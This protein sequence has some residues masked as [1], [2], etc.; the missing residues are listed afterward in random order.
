MAS[1]IDYPFFMPWTQ[2]DRQHYFEKGYVLIRR[3]IDGDTLAQIDAQFLALA[4]GTAKVSEKMVIMKD[5]AYLSRDVSGESPLHEIN[6]LLSFE[7]DPILW[8]FATD[9]RILECVRDLVGPDVMTLSTNVFNKPPGLDS[10]HPLHQDLRY[11][12][13]RPADGIVATWTA[14]EPCTRENGCLAIIPGSHRGELLEHGE[15]DWERV[16]HGF[17]AA[18][19]VDIQ[20]RVHVEMEP[21]DTLFFHP[22]LVHGSGRNRSNGFRRAIS[23]HYASITCERPADMTGRRPRRRRIQSAVKRVPSN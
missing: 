11:F 16:N 22:L 17:F 8:P 12:A 5:V 2:S 7:D 14:I 18:K 15:P 23:M 13:I 6:K 10:R 21:G 20:A 9:R 4:S 1:R 3:L 19:E